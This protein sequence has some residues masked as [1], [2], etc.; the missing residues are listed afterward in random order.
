MEKK[1]F[2]PD[3][4]L[5]AYFFKHKHSSPLGFGTMI[6]EVR[7]PRDVKEQWFRHRTG[8]RE[9]SDLGA[10]T[11]DSVVSM[12][13]DQQTQSGRVAE[14]TRDF[15]VPSRDLMLQQSKTFKQASS[16]DSI[17]DPDDALRIINES[18]SQTW[19][20]YKKLL[21]L[22]L[23]RERARL[24]LPFGTYVTFHWKQDLWNLF[25]WCEK[26]RSLDAQSEIRQYA[27][28]IENCLKNYF[29]KCYSGWEKSL[30]G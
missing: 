3:E 27:D 12:Y 15:Y 10:E 19:D 24:V 28:V 20:A 25:D 8:W 7:A 22:G 4:D 14:Y 29:P 9:E 26:R 1:T 5:L 2:R 30:A 17:D 11:I 6:F 16:R 21:A 13:H 23:S 18:Y